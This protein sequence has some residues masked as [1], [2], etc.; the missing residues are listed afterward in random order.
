MF[1]EHCCKVPS[2]Q[3]ITFYIK[4]KYIYG[5]LFLTRQLTNPF[6]FFCKKIPTK[7]NKKN[8]FFED[9]NWVETRVET[10]PTLRIH[11]DLKIGLRLGTRF[12][13]PKCRFD[14]VGGWKRGQTK[15]F[16]PGKLG[17]NKK[18]ARSKQKK[19]GSKQKKSG[20]KQKSVESQSR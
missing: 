16:R 20:S 1:F 5:F 7:K 9:L 14:P 2:V 17:Q 4:K 12:V 10:K 8:V 15:T 3:S 18:N 13:P 19:S 11:L 6:T